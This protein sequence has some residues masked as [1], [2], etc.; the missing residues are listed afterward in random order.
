MLLSFYLTRQ[1]NRQTRSN[2]IKFGV[3]DNQRRIAWRPSERSPW[4]LHRFLRRFLRVE[5]QHRGVRLLWR[6]D[7]HKQALRAVWCERERFRPDFQTV[8]AY[9]RF[10][11]VR[12]A[13]LAAP[14]LRWRPECIACPLRVYEWCL[15]AGTPYKP[16]M[17]RVVV[18]VVVADVDTP[19]GCPVGTSQISR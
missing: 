12:R 5:L 13:P 8:Y 3:F 2:F 11:P 10:H 16:K 7:P 14:F 9:L 18:A 1:R 15:C 6:G 17:L 19:L 4:H